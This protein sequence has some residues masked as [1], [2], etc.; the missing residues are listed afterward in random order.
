MQLSQ[1]ENI[2]RFSQPFSKFWHSAKTLYNFPSQANFETFILELVRCVCSDKELGF[3]TLNRESKMVEPF[4]PLSFFQAIRNNQKVYLRPLDD[5]HTL[6]EFDAVNSICLTKAVGDTLVTDS[7]LIGL[8]Q[9]SN[10]LID[11]QKNKQD[12]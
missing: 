6:F 10:G 1:L 11:I 5:Y 2:I 8:L 7:P 12:V 9:I 4:T 3:G